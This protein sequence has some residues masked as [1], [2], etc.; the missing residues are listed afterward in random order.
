[1]SRASIARAYDS[2]TG[3]TSAGV[4]GR[5]GGAAALSAGWLAITGAVGTG[6]GGVVAACCTPGGGSVAD[7]VRGCVCTT[8]CGT[9]FVCGA[10]R[11]GGFTGARVVPSGGAGL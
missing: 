6:R 4:A 8:V 9:A 3:A 10:G 5:G 11:V 2:I 1:M 7:G